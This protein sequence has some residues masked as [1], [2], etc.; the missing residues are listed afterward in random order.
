[1]MCWLFRLLQV[2]GGC[3]KII[4]INAPIIY[5]LACHEVTI[6]K[7]KAGKVPEKTLKENKADNCRNAEKKKSVKPL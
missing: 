6:R 4:S 7:P 5:V 3:P 2:E 1:M